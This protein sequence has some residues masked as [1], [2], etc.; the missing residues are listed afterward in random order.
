MSCVELTTS[1][2]HD[3]A[4]CVEVL[5]HMQPDDNI[6]RRIDSLLAAGRVAVVLTQFA[7]APES[8]FCRS[9]TRSVVGSWY[10]DGL[11]GKLKDCLWKDRPLVSAEV[12]LVPSPQLSRTSMV[13]KISSS[14][15]S[16]ACFPHLLRHHG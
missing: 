5:R 10:N 11:R 16:L 7:C 1:N 14:Y 13:S 15:T 2:M 9:L 3:F 6:A 8:I 12:T 4:A